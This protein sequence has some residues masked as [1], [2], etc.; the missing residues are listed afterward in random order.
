[1]KNAL[2]LFGTDE[3]KIDNYNDSKTRDDMTSSSQNNVN[4][5]ADFDIINRSA[6]AMNNFNDTNHNKNKNEKDDKENYNDDARGKKKLEKIINVDDNRQSKALYSFLPLFLILSLFTA[7]LDNDEK[8][9]F[10]R[11]EL[12]TVLEG[13]IVKKFRVLC[14]ENDDEYSRD[15]E[16]S[17]VFSFSPLHSTNDK[18]KNHES[19]K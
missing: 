1:M 7:S 14:C 2:E 12:L 5:V 3:E 9:H 17:T 10:H 4:Q 13:N 16:T 6:T 11:T 15:M 8:F 18:E 19:D